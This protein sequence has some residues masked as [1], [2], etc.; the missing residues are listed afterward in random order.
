MEKKEPDETIRATISGDI[1]G[2]VAVG[3]H[4]YQEQTNIPASQAVSREDLEALKKALL[5]LR[6]R[7]AAE[8]PAEIKTAAVERVDE[9]AEAVAQ[10]KPD[11]TT[12]EYVKQW[13]TKHAPGLAGAATGVIVHPIV[14]RLVEAAGDALV[15]EFSRRFGASPTK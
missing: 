8:A 14:G 4:I 15:S 2:Q 6:T 1:R 10:E 3:S 9:L 12:M 7:V 5:E 11:L 13:F